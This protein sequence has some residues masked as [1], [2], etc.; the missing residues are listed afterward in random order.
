MLRFVGGSE[1]LGWAALTGR[2]NSIALRDRILNLLVHNLPKAF[3]KVSAAAA[4]PSLHTRLT[5][6]LD[7]RP[8]APWPY[9]GIERGLTMLIVD[10]FVVP[11]LDAHEQLESNS[12]SLLKGFV[13]SLTAVRNSA[14]MKS[15][16]IVMLLPW[17]TFKLSNVIVV[18]SAFADKRRRLATHTAT[19]GS[20]LLPASFS[21]SR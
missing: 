2:R 9:F 8:P 7:H 14:E 1:H 10:V 19:V 12:V 17:V 21:P 3:S 20:A 5:E 18:A 13:I 4:P 16:L 11:K 15:P 6:E